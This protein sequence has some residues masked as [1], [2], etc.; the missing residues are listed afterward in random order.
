V[1]VVVALIVFMVAAIFSWGR[2]RLRRDFSRYASAA[3]IS[4]MRTW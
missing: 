3:T 2:R 1:W 4:S